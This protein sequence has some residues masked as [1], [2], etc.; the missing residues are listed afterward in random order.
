M[1]ICYT[2]CYFNGSCF[3]SDKIQILAS[4][5]QKNY[6]FSFSKV[7]SVFLFL[8]KH[9]FI[10][11]IWWKKNRSQ[12]SCSFLG[13][14]VKISQDCCWT[15][16]KRCLLSWAA[17]SPESRLSEAVK[18]ALHEQPADESFSSQ[19]AALM[20]DSSSSCSSFIRLNSSV[21]LSSECVEVR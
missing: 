4:F 12:E 20:F 13:Y 7:T 1:Q 16:W 3:D 8:H 21:R 18:R 2:R 19:T 9:V 15:L 11:G 17:E 6:F 5:K 14:S 10:M